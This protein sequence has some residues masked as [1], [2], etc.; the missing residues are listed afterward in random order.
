MLSSSLR[1]ADAVFNVIG[2]RFGVGVRGSWFALYKILPL[3]ILYGV[4]HAHGRSGE[5]VV[6]CAIAMQ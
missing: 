2:Q 3:P 1:T 4:W 5:G 6:Y